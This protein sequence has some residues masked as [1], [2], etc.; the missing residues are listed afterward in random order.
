MTIEAFYDRTD[1]VGSTIRT[2]TTNLVEG[3]VFVIVVLFLMLKNL[4]AGLIAAVAIPLSMLCAF[5]G[6]RA[7]GISGNLMS[8]GAID[9]GLIVDGALII[10][11]NA[12]RHVA[13]RT[14][15]LG[16][17]LTRA[18]RDE[19]VYRSAVE[20]PERGR[21]RRDHH[22]ASSTCRS[23]RSAAPRGR[24]SARWR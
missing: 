11:E 7:M 4:R 21:V 15:Q 6:M 13:E 19:V 1:L 8:L 24:C 2:V 22:R 9:F 3:G 18:E 23:S 17:P 5:I 20:M 10:V 14:K 12:V 16:R